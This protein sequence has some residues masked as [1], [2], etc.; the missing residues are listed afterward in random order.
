MAD[1][2][3]NTI[4]RSTTDG[5]TPEVRDS[6]YYQHTQAL[7]GMAEIQLELSR[8]LETIQADVTSEGAPRFG[9]DVLLERA[10]AAIAKINISARFAM[11]RLPAELTQQH[12]TQQR[13]VIHKNRATEA[14][15]I[16][17]I[18]ENILSRLFL[19]DLL[20]AQQVDRN[21][22]NIIQGSLVLQ[23]ALFLKPRLTGPFK[24]FPCNN[25]E[26]LSRSHPKIPEV[27]YLPLYRYFNHLADPYETSMITDNTS[28]PKLGKTIFD[29]QISERLEKATV[30][31]KVSSMLI[32]QPPVYVMQ[33]TMDCCE[34]GTT[35]SKTSVDKNGR[36][37]IK[38]KHGITIGHMLE[39]IKTM[40]EL[41]QPCR[42]RGSARKL[43]RDR[44]P[45]NYEQEAGPVTLSPTFQTMVTLEQDNPFFLY[46]MKGIARARTD[47][48]SWSEMVMK[49]CGMYIW[50]SK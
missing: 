12:L 41:H 7:K 38:A 30:G 24:V 15:H 44:G 1:N 47:P 6:N 9:H 49:I 23:Q 34:D 48:P 8:I 20:R 43:R 42:F 29:F 36:F 27:P 45:E 18:A 26:P 31:A 14:F 25:P 2:G 28:T 33:V 39:A 40:R 19:E 5:S 46:W 32:C 35:K 16:P 50:V 3:K 13:L 37:M 11:K 10:L 22:S 21:I 4:D 17:E